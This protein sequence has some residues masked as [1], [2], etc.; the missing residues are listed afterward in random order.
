MCW[1]E[2]TA[3]E[4]AKLFTQTIEISTTKNHCGD[5]KHCFLH[6][7]SVGYT[8]NSSEKLKLSIYQLQGQQ[9]AILANTGTKP[10]SIFSTVHKWAALSTCWFQVV[11]FEH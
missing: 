11:Q 2:I 6:M 7:S 1:E 3:E 10:T 4:A 9:Q 5:A 8:Q